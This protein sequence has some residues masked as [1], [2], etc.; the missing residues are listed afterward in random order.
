[1]IND[2]TRNKVKVGMIYIG[3]N[4]CSEFSDMMSVTDTTSRGSAA[5]SSTMLSG[6]TL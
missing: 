5:L 3:E 6:R 2:V 1:M 4:L